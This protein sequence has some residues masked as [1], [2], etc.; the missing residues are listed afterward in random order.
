[1]LSIN[2]DAFL[3]CGAVLK[4]LIGAELHVMS[5]LLLGHMLQ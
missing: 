4:S 2:V 1:M 3:Q 5:N